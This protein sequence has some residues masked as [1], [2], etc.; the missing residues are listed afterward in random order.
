MSSWRLA[1]RET[2]AEIDA[3]ESQIQRFLRGE[4][5]ADGLRPLRTF[6]GVYGQRH[7][8]RYMVRVKVPQGILEPEQLERLGQ[9]AEFS[10]GFAYVTTRQDI[11][12]HFLRLENVAAALRALADVGLT[13]REAGGNI[14][15]NVTCDPFDGICPDAAFAVTPHSNAVTRHF[16]RNPA[17]QALPRK[18]KIAFS[19]C[20]HDHTL[21]WIHDIGAQA[22][23]KDG[24]RG[25]ACWWVAGWAPYLGRRCC[26]MSSSLRTSSCGPARPWCGYSTVPANAG[27]GGRPA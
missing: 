23:I 26:L 15:R 17:A 12:F 20:P 25:F 5:T 24:R 21:A 4:L 3:L 10:R 16:L 2:W 22:V 9:V 27:T 13:T 14:V 8:D 6:Y 7:K 19:G 11:Q 18:I 1:D